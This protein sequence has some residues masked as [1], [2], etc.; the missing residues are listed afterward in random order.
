MNESNTSAKESDNPI[1]KDNAVLEARLD[2]TAS[3]MSDNHYAQQLINLLNNR[4]RFLSISSVILLLFAVGFGVAA[5]MIYQQKQFT[6]Q[7]WKTAEIARKE[8]QSQV[9]QLQQ[10]AAKASSQLDS[11]KQTVSSIQ[12][13]LSLQVDKL[14]ATNNDLLAQNTAL[15][16][17]VKDLTNKN[18]QLQV[19][20]TNAAQ[21]LDNAISSQ[22]TNATML[23]GL[24][25]RLDT[26]KANQSGWDKQ[27]Q[28]MEN[29]INNR[30]SAFEALA[31]RNQSL[32]DQLQAEQLSTQ[33][34]KQQYDA[35]QEDYSN[36]KNLVDDLQQR[37]Q[38]AQQQIDQLQKDKDALNRSLKELVGG[39][40][41][42]SPSASLKDM[43]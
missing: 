22:N 11:Q 25:T 12:S 13:S 28:R 40:P 17:E 1:A 5:L 26:L 14:K 34:Y 33:K 18:S 3:Q 19:Q 23:N 35:Q 31:R 37:L 39:S 32:Q 27:K 9:V 21:K 43:P 15:S 16:N 2:T 24:R 8:L 41:T 7:A 42:P 6:Q 36:Q 38:G 20:L 30:K 29:E 4:T 10:Q